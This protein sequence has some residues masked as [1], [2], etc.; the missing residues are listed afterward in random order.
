VART[1]LISALETEGL[2]RTY[3]ALA[4]AR[5]FQPLTGRV[6]LCRASGAH[7]KVQRVQNALAECRSS[8]QLTMSWR[9]AVCVALGF[10]EVPVTVIV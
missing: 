5:C 9:V 7:E 3:G 8:P 4:W 10:D 6:N 1:H 2:C